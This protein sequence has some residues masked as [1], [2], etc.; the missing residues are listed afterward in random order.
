[1]I[2]RVSRWVIFGIML[3]TCFN[4]TLL[5]GIAADLCHRIDGKDVCI[6]RIKRSAKRYWEYRVSL[7]VEGKVQPTEIYNC[8]R[9][10][11]IKSN[12]KTVEFKPQG[13]GEIIA[14]AE[15]RYWWDEWS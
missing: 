11:L 10:L 14:D 8:R 7:K 6:H 4:L 12:G 3:L 1:M 9:Q 13:I 5:P 2:R 15:G